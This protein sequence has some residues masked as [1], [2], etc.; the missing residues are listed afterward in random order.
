MIGVLIVNLGTPSSPT[1]LALRRYLKQFLSDPRV[2]ELPRIPWWILLNL[3]ILNF[4]CFASARS[5]QK[6]WTPEGSPLLVASE[7]QLEKL[8]NSLNKATND[9]FLVKLG[10]SYGQPGIQQALVEIQQANVNKIVVLPLYPQY[11][12]S[13]TGSVFTYVVN[14]LGNWRRIP[15]LNSIHGYHDHPEYIA[16]IANKISEYWH[17]HGR[18]EKLLF[19]YH[20]L[21]QRYVDA[22]DSY[23]D[24]C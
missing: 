19:S 6:I 3:V 14:T 11:S 9:R 23:Y 10:M 16:A 17:N 7:R 21:P 18:G 4:R 20:G 8:Q 2:V 24:E 22:G 1:P 15:S 5:Y 12:G 13:T